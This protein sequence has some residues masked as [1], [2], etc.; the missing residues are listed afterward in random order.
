M[1]AREHAHTL[2]QPH[3]YNVSRLPVTGNKINKNKQLVILRENGSISCQMKILLVTGK[4]HTGY[5]VKS[6]YQKYS[7][8]RGAVS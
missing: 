8:Q 4:F 2:T 3:I 5:H 1:H 7:S 6:F